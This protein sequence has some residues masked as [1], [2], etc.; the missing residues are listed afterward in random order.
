MRLARVIREAA[1]EALFVKL[2]KAR[3][4]IVAKWISPSWNGVPDR[5][6]LKGISG[7]AIA[8]QWRWSAPPSTYEE[9]EAR[10][11]ELLAE[12]IEFVEL[13]A[14][15]KRPTILQMRRHE[16]LTKLGFKVSVVDSS[17]AA[18]KWYA[19]RP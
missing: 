11:R 9:A 1:V 8:L 12:C 18:E 16:Q 6:V 3:R 14:P 13:K 17:V 15:G 19:D 10:A 7:A 5:I 2:G 4:W